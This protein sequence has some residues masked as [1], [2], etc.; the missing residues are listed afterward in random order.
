MKMAEN[1]MNLILFIVSGKASFKYKDV[2][3]WDHSGIYLFVLSNY[4]TE[5]S[6]DEQEFHTLSY[7]NYAFS[8][9]GFSFKIGYIWILVMRFQNT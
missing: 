3:I 7:Y 9:Y 6:F 1:V 2:E 4:L 8:P 5:V